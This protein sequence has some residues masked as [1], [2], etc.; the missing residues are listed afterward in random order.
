MMSM[1]RIEICR[2]L[3]KPTLCLSLAVS[4]TGCLNG[5]SGGSDTDNTD[6]PDPIVEKEVGFFQ[7]VQSDEQLVA[8]VTRQI[9]R[10]DDEVEEGVGEQPVAAI[11]LDSGSDNAGESTGDFSGTYLQEQGVDESDIVKYDGTHLYV[12]EQPNQLYGWIA[13]DSVI[14][15]IAIASTPP[16]VKPTL[17]E[18]Y[19]KIRVLETS[20][21]PAGATE[22]GTITLSEPNLRIDGLFLLPAG[23]GDAA[24]PLMAVVGAGQLN[25]RWDYWSIASQWSGG[26]TALIIEDISSPA[27]SKETYKLEIEGHLVTSRRIGDVVYLVTRFYPNVSNGLFELDENTQV[28]EQSSNADLDTLAVA[29]LM[30]A[31]V[32]NDGEQSALLAATDCLIPSSDNSGDSYYYNTFVTITAI[33]LRDPE[34]FKS[35]CFDAHT[36]GYYASQQ[37]IYF[38]GYDWQNHRTAIHKFS[39]QDG[40][41]VYA[42][43]GSVAGNLGWRNPSFR[44]GE[45]NGILHVV[46]SPDNLSVVN[47]ILPLTT[48]ENDVL[49]GHRLTLLQESSTAFALEEVTHIPNAE[50]PT[51]IGKPGEDVFAVRYTGNRAYVVTFRRIDPLYI[52]DISDSSKPT[53]TGELEIPGFSSLL[54]P[55]GDSLLLGFGHDADEEGVQLGYKVELFDVSDATAPVSIDSVV[56]GDRGTYSGV[57]G[58]YHA[59]TVLPANAERNLRFAL[60]VD[61]YGENFRWQDTGLHLYEVDGADTPSTASIVSKGALIIDEFDSTN[62]WGY[63]QGRQQRSV[64]HGDAVHYV[65]DDDVYSATWG[66]ADT[67]VGPQ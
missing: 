45:R 47:D 67:L 24:P 23:E 48:E 53:I 19:G 43:S 8:H 37:A 44:F 40:Q 10:S 17:E 11:E 16:G 7:E 3:V 20:S 66:N 5:G 36:D 62:G 15:P 21:E 35:I 4:L 64:I 50:A 28:E 49:T 1:K 18:D 52:I 54:H 38:S 65:H 59:L 29:E 34:A 6:S 31:K 25:Y 58:D 27:D 46:S 61:R 14:E 39:F 30:P 33:N 63:P 13:I 56:L 9:N 42:G 22:V 26:R 12:V 2:R 57:D 51:P 60:P 55:V 32:I 41:P